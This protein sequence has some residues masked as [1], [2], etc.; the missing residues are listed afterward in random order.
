MTIDA[1]LIADLRRQKTQLRD[2]RNAARATIRKIATMLDGAEWT[3]EHLEWIA[4]EIRAA[5]EIIGPP[6]NDTNGDHQ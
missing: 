2:E 6:I 3:P 5:G 4:D 1:Q